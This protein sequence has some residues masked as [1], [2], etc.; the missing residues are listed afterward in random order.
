MRTFR[1]RSYARICGLK[2]KR[3]KKEYYIYSNL[4]VPITASSEGTQG[5]R[6]DTVLNLVYELKK[7]SKKIKKQKS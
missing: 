5:E 7:F 3:K 1:R 4:I 2:L 6:D